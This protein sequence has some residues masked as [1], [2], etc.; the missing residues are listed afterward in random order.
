MHKDMFM[1]GKYGYRSKFAQQFLPFLEKVAAEVDK[2]IA[3]DQH[4]KR[5]QQY[6]SKFHQTNAPFR[7]AYAQRRQKINEFREK[8]SK[9]VR[10]RNKSAGPPEKGYVW[11]DDS[12]LETG[13][14][15][16]GFWGP[17]YDELPFDLKNDPELKLLPISSNGIPPKT[18]EEQ[19]EKDYVLLAII[20]DWLL[21]SSLPIDDCSGHKPLKTLAFVID[22]NLADEGPK[23]VET[24]LGHV[25]AD[26]DNLKPAETE[27][28]TTVAKREKESCLLKLYE[29]TLKVIV[30]AFME[31]F[32]PKP[33]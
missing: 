33:K 22:L 2:L 17:P 12:P 29:V 4:R 15:N 19:L 31:R 28:G 1:N 27:Q 24:A 30:D 20:H 3:K 8:S 6:A 32:W 13:D 16:F 10:F 9:D 7:E 23:I 21:Q 26:L 5:F 25:K 18:T 11:Y 14:P